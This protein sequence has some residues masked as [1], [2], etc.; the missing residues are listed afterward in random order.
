MNIVAV[1]RHANLRFGGAQITIWTLLRKLQD[2]YGY[3]CAVFTSDGRKYRTVRAGIPC[4]TYRDTDELK[5]MLKTARPRVLLATLEPIAEAVAVASRFQIPTLAYFQSYEY[6][7]PTL[8]ERQRWGVDLTRQYPSRDEIEFALRTADMLVA[9]SEHVQRRFAGAYNVTPRLLY[10]ELEPVSFSVTNKPKYITGICGSR[11]KGF[12]IFLSLAD[13]FPQEKFL[14][15]GDVNPEFRTR[16][17]ERGNIVLRGHAAPKH[18]LRDSK[19]VLVPS[20]WQEP[21]GRIAVEAMG[22]G[23]PAL[24]SCTGGLQEIVG[25]SQLGVKHFRSPEAWRV[26][27]TALLASAQL[28]GEYSERGR[29]LAAKFLRGDSTRRLAQWIQELSARRVPHYDMAPL[30]HL[31][32]AASHKTAFSIVNT[33]WRDALAQTAEIQLVPI[34]ETAERQ[35]QPPDVVIDHDYAQ[36]FMQT[37]PPPNGKWVVVRT[38]DFGRFPEA[39]VAKINAEC[40][41]LWVF[42]RWVRQQAIASGIM[43]NRVRVVPL[44]IDPQLFT[45]RGKVLPLPRSKRFK[46]LFVGATVLRKGIDILLR[47]YQQAFTADDDVCLVIKDHTRDVFYTGISFGDEIAKIQSNPHAPSIHYINDYFSTARL[48]SLYRACDVGVFPYRA[49]GFGIPI[50]EALA[51]GIPAIVPRLGAGLDFCNDTNAFLVPARR[52]SLPVRGNF[53]F[54]TLGFQ[55][56]LNYVDFCQVPVATLVE[57]L[58]RAYEMSPAELAARGRAGSELA[59]SKFTWRDSVACALKHIQSLEHQTTPYRLKQTRRQAAA[60][61]E[62]LETARTLYEDFLPARAGAT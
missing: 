46:F 57:Y 45:P 23:I 2:E 38:W 4:V 9:N 59:R 50:L 32:G 58:R 42:S 7:P 5:G 44:G 49:E 11:Y 24:V 17:H 60:R 55:A 15:V 37:Q 29:K 14:L 27:L 21:F 35:S 56:E 1:V 39:W 48:A 28:R 13:A 25:A 30:V 8:A 61:A 20:Q 54:N 26:R 51:C 31:R 36:D 6:C 53:A 41:Q 40:D 3:K 43:A 47:A 18:F 12:E 19:I 10:P 16:V 33:A 52:I 34:Q 62:K 22:A